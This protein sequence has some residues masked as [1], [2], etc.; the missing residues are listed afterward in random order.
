MSLLTVDITWD[1][2]TSIL[3]T[4]L[5]LREAELL[6]TVTQQVGAAL[7][8][9]PGPSFLYSELQL[10]VLISLESQFLA[11]SFSELLVPWRRNPAVFISV[12]PGK[13]LHV[14]LPPTIPEASNSFLRT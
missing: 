10:Q 2:S 5:E 14:V 4:N 12:F 13:T 8:Y 1:V 9:S 7:E 11:V 6:F 3:Q